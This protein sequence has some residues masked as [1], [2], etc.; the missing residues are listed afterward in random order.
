M[1]QRP[2]AQLGEILIA[3]GLIAV[4][5]FVV[6]DTQS[7]ANTAGAGGVGPRLFPYLIGVGLTLCGA[8]L[9]WQAISGGWRRMVPVPEHARPDWTAFALISVGIVLHMV[10]IGWAGFVIAGT[11]LFVLTARG[12]GS[13]KPVRDAAIALVLSITVYLIFTHGL[14]LKLPASPL[15]VI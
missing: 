15:G 7:I 11:L 2:P 10:V 5:T 3:L 12:F 8:V 1:M 4:G 13:R 9:G 6:V 14:G